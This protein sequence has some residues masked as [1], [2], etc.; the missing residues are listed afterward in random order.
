ME[1]INIYG[2]PHKGIRNALGQLSIKVGSLNINNEDQINEVIAQADEISELLKLHLHSEEAHVLPPVEAK[3][4]GSTEHNHDDHEAMAAL[5]H[6][7]VEKIHQI[8]QQRTVASV[9]AA[10][11]KVN[12]FIKEYFRH[13]EEEEVDLNKVIWQ[14][15]EDQEIMG[16][17]GK[18]LS[19]FTPEQFFKW[20]KYII[21]ALH[22]HE[23]EI[24]LGGFKQNAPQ[25]AYNHTIQGLKPYVSE[26]Q[27]AFI[28]SI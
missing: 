21:P 5:E 9:T 10:Y 12:E 14:H 20:F 25:E 16:W 1:R 22:P 19:E 3:V 28:S 7:M 24:M 11:D 2:F 26:G 13:M 27:Y 15:F 8:K 17:Q 23:Q 6:E 4:P 18:I